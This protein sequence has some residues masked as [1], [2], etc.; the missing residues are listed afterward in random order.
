V[1]TRLN[2]HRDKVT[3]T[4]DCAFMAT[5]ARREQKTSANGKDYLRVSV[6]VSEGDA[7]PWVTVVAFDPEAITTADRFDIDARVHVEGRISI[8]EWTGNDGAKRHGLPVM[9]WHCRL[10]HIGRNRPKRTSRRGLASRSEPS[11]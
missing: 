4:I 1:R 10:P 7:A 8:S 11:S 9:S 2:Q 6:C 3:P 5:V